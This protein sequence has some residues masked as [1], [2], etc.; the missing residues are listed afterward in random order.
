MVPIRRMVAGL[1]LAVVTVAC[2]TADGVGV[3]SS[4]GG[5]TGDVLSPREPPGGQQSATVVETSEQRPPVDVMEAAI[6][7]NPDFAC[8]IEQ[9]QADGAAYED[10]LHEMY[11]QA[12]GEQ[13]FTDAQQLP[14]FVTGA[15]ARPR[16]VSRSGCR[17]PARSPTSSTR[18]PTTSTR[19]GLRSRPVPPASTTRRSRPPSRR[20][21][22]WGCSLSP[23]RV[24]RPLA[25]VGSR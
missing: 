25:P 2:G 17:S 15:Y 11:A 23:V 10:A 12:V 19:S 21:A 6:A 24:T 1:A 16:R 8:V 18:A 4:A 22:R 7:G 13:L 3:E 20:R 9:R 5:S 14:G